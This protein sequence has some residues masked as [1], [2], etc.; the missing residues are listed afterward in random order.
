MKLPNVR[1]VRVRLEGNRLRR[2][3]IDHADVVERQGARRQPRVAG[4][5]H[6]VLDRGHPRADLLRL[7]FEQIRAA[8]DQLGTR[9]PEQPCFELVGHLR[10]RGDRGNHV[11]A[12]DVDLIGQGQ[13]DRITRLGSWLGAFPH[14][15]RVDARFHPR[16]EYA[17]PVA[18]MHRAG[19]HSSAEAAE[20][21]AGPV[22]PLHRHAEPIHR[23]RAP[24]LHRL[25]VVHYRR[26]LVP[27]HAW[28]GQ[29]EVVA[30]ERRDRNR[31]HAGDAAA[32]RERRVLVH[33]L[34]EDLLLVAHQIHLV[35]G[36]Q[37]VADPHHRGD[38]R[39]PAGLRQHAFPRVDQDDG[40]FR[41]R[42]AGGHVARVLLVP[43]R[44]GDDE[45]AVRRGEEAVGH[46]DRDALLAL[47]LQP[48]HQEREVEPR[49]LRAEA[50]RV[51]FERAELIL[52]HAPRLVEQAADERG[53]AVVHAAAGDEAQQRPAQK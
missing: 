35:N 42:G 2:R 53:L 12:A 27:R 13:R 20:V 18:R 23:R 8:G 15:N 32:G 4:D 17:H 31:P 46:V 47:G 1:S 52:E 21:R 48:V 43:G 33:D 37:D 45:P 36:E 5:V 29:D 34:L 26:A 38:A 10:R 51:G 30:F 41:G 25:Q 9:H 7:R 3:E 49:A 50:A 19:A 16:G 40:Q 28:S 14:H 44:V 11:A 39:V 22:D 6:A 24:R